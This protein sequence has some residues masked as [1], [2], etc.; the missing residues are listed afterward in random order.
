MGVFYQV[1]G[2]LKVKN[3]LPTIDLVDKY[4]NLCSDDMGIDILFQ[5][6]EHAILEFA[7]GSIMSHTNV[8]DIDDMIEEFKKFVIQPGFLTYD[9]DGVQGKIHLAPVAEGD[10]K[11]E[12]DFTTA[13]IAE[14]TATSTSVIVDIWCKKCEVSGSALIHKKDIQF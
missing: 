8:T 6:D 12:P 5:D 3:E 14:D 10:C 11:H 4:N 9:F 1:Y 13:A 7:G 2:I